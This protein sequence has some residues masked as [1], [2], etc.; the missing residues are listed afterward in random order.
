MAHRRLVDN[1]RLKSVIDSI[2][3][4]PTEKINQL[5]KELKDLQTEVQNI[6]DKLYLIKKP[7]II[8]PTNGQTD[9]HDL[10][11]ASEFETVP[12]YDG[13]HTAS[14]WEIAT[15]S[16]FSTIVESSYNDTIHK[17]VYNWRNLEA[18]KTYYVR[19]R[20]RSDN[21]ISEWSDPV[22]FTTA[23]SFIKTPFLTCLNPGSCYPSFVLTPFETVNLDDSWESTHWQIAKDPDFNTLVVDEIVTDNQR[24]YFVTDDILS[25]NSTYYVRAKY[26]S[27]N[28]NFS[29][30]SNVY[31]LET[32]LYKI[33]NVIPSSLTENQTYNFIVTHDGGKFFDA[34]RYTLKVSTT[35]GDV[36]VSGIQFSWSI[37]GLNTSTYAVVEITVLDSTTNKPVTD[38]YTKKVFIYY[39]PAVEDDAVVVTDY[40][41][42]T[43]ESQGWSF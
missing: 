19:V 37:P 9:F 4:I 38:P 35:V 7:S 11:K 15:D 24:E 31:K 43:Y 30:W 32:G 16:D 22:K 1:R 17:K 3:T 41:S 18:N 25:T 36:A 5:E 23:N 13:K 21:H 39:V 20:Y 40:K 34:D 28:D 12:T 10:I 2:S 29:L 6:D 14:D 26:K 27:S 42:L 8:T 33:D